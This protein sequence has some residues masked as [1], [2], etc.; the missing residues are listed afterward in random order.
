MSQTFIDDCYASGHQ[1]QTDLQSFEDNFAALKSSF[2]GANAP[3]DPT[4][5]C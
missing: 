3:P 2:P 1:A 4:L 5:F